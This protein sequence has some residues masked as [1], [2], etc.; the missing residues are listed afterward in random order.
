[1]KTLKAIIGI[2]TLAF[3]IVTGMFFNS[4]NAQ[5]VSIAPYSF[6]AWGSTPHTSQ[7]SLT[8]EGVGI[9][10]FFTTGQIYNNQG[11]ELKNAFALSYRH[12]VISDIAKLGIIVFDKPYPT[13]SE[14]SVNFLIDLGYTFGAFRVSYIHISNAGLARYNAGYDT[15]QLTVPIN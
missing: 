4:A 8:Y 2:L 14:Q 5:E 6:R 10:G 12:E 3:L 9:H 11:R 7:L 15:I 1:M 13:E